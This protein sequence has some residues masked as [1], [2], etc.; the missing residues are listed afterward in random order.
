M[1]PKTDAQ[2]RAQKAYMGKYE[3]LEI[4]ITPDKKKRLEAHTEATGESV[5]GFMNR[6]I[7]ETMEND[8]AH[9]KAK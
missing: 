8:K 3:R 1:A 7:D 4:R 5:S 2:K 9:Q 6:A